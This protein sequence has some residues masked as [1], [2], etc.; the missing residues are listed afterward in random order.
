MAHLFNC[1]VEEKEPANG[2]SSSQRYGSKLELPDHQEG[3]Y[4]NNR[5]EQKKEPFFSADPLVHIPL[6]GPPSAWPHLFCKPV[7]KFDEDRRAI[8][9]RVLAGDSRFFFGSDSAPH[10]RESKESDCC[11][12]GAYTAPMALPAL[13][14]WFEEENALDRVEPFFCEFGRKFYNV[15][16]NAGRIELER[17]PW[18]VPAVSQGCVPLMAGEILPWRLVE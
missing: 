9:D 18:T 1:K 11:P 12:A 13:V 16:G 3:Q 2:H 5:I 7:V 6:V 15:P 14:T 8:R 10:L 17:K 4:G